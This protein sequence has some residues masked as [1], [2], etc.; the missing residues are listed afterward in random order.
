VL[1]IFFTGHPRLRRWRTLNRG[2]LVDA[3][4]L[5]H[6]ASM[7]SCDASLLLG[8]LRRWRMEIDRLTDLVEEIPAPSVDAQHV[9]LARALKIVPQAQTHTRA[10]LH[11]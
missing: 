9:L 11:K 4:R 7:R 6:R 10:A 1:P 2:W 3:G 8:R 5:T